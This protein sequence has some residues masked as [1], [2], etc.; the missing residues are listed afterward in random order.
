MH[1]SSQSCRGLL[2]VLAIVLLWTYTYRIAENPL[3]W[4]EPR[5]CLVASEMIHRADYVVPRVLGEPYANKPPLQ[6]WL[7]V[8]LSGN[9]AARVGAVPLRAISV[10]SVFGVAMLLWAL[11]RGQGVLK[12]AW[13]PSLV[14]LTMGITLQYGRS[15]EL[16]PLLTF[17]VTASLASFEIGRRRRL[18]WL[19]WVVPQALLGAGILTKGL[20]PLFF[21]PPALYH[22]LKD[23]PWGRSARRAFVAGLLVEVALVSA[24]VIPY[25]IR[26]PA[27]ALVVRWAVELVQR[28]PLRSSASQLLNHL[29]VYPLEVLGN[30]LPWSALFLLWLLPET[31]RS[32]RKRLARDSFLGL[33]LTVSLWAFIVLWLLP[34]AKGRYLMPAYPFMA[35]LLAHVLSASR[36]ALDRVGRC[37]PWSSLRSWVER[38]FVDAWWGWIAVA[39]LWA[40]GLAVAASAVGSYPVWQPLSAGIVV[41]GAVGFAVRFLWRGRL[42]FGGLLLAGLLFGVVYAGASRVM[43]AE[44]HRRRVQEAGEVASWI[45]R[46]LPVV[47]SRDVPRGVCFEISRRLDRVLQRRPPPGSPYY[48]VAGADDGGRPGGIMRGA[49]H[50]LFLWEMQSAIAAGD[51]ADVHAR[52]PGEGEE[53]LR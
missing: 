8:L 16:D 9:T 11:Q 32:M 2:L 41:I 6:S 38:L 40:A 3:M 26:A 7:I 19:Q 36:P 22:A 39:W 23:R 18:P 21:Y 4:E 30:T 49:A 44:R 51:T 24:W 53:G 17:F 29:L 45:R 43:I 28:T 47:C 34:G 42:V 10:M 31:R 14:F 13:I 15:G 52:G 37:A 25:A 35:V 46:P 27:G 33:S 48:L 20:A 5:R 50:G 12:D 1:N